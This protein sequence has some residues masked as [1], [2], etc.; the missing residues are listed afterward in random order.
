ML[1]TVDKLQPQNNINR[2]KNFRKLF[3]I[4]FFPIMIFYTIFLSP[5]IEP[6]IQDY[7]FSIVRDFKHEKFN[8]LTP[9]YA[10]SEFDN[11]YTLSV[12]TG[13][14]A[15]SMVQSRTKYY[16]KD[17]RI[18]AMSKFLGDYGSPM[19]P[20]AEVFVQEAD[21]YGLDWRLVAGISG[22]ESAFGNITPNGSHN[23]W[24]WRGINAN[25]DGWSF[26]ESWPEAISYI[27][28][29]MALGYGTNLSPFDIESTY[30]PPCG[31]AYGH[32]WA[33]GVTR[34]MNELDYYLDNLSNL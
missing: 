9:V 23:G 11:R 25:Q 15:L 31:E 16:V 22:V 1:N 27:T 34:F 30:C 8:Y 10:K 5:H 18:L 6:L 24:G 33:N 12:L 17:P 32:P 2:R 28:E 4:S 7:L 29:R 19:Q 14:D 26:F 20:Y 13:E 21:R 3:F